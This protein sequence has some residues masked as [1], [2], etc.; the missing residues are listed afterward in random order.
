MQ[1][2][3]YYHFYTIAAAAGVSDNAQVQPASA[4]VVEVLKDNSVRAFYND[5]AFEVT[6]PQHAN[7]ASVCQQ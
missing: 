2:I 1:P 3:D 7:P 4:L 6:L 5:V